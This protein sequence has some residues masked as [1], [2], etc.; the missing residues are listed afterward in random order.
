MQKRKY[1]LVNR[2]TNKLF[3]TAATR[4]QAREL[5]R[6]AGFKHHIVNTERA[7]VVR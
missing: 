3:R 5:K 7:E 6:N 4:E 2:R 1:A